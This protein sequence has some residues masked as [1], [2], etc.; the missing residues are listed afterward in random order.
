[1]LYKTMTELEH[2]IEEPVGTSTTDISDSE[3]QVV[4]GMGVAIQKTYETKSMVWK[5][6]SN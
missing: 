4:L 2:H 3:I 5:Q 6:P 1:M